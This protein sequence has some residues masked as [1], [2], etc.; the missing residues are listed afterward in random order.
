M[1]KVYIAKQSIGRFKT[2]EQVEGLTE[3]RAEYL[4]SK[5][6]IE[7]EEVEGEDNTGNGGEEARLDKLTKAELTA[8]LDDMGIKY[9]DSD[10]KAEL[11]ALFPAE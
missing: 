4:A 11:I 8:K 3:E 9:N 1:S 6:A 10:T 5:G 7:I 2:G